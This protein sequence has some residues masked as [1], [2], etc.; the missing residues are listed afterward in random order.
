MLVQ[1]S[2]KALLSIPFGTPLSSDSQ[3]YSIPLKGWLK[4]RLLS[5][6]LRASDSVGLRGGPEFPFLPSFQLMLMF[7]HVK[8]H[9]FEDHCSNLLFS[10]FPVE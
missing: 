7:L 8:G 4:H 3:T 10:S 5:L 2:R 1:E 9:Y 6:A